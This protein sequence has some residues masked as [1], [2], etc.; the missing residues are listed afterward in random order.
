MGGSAKDF[1]G[2][3]RSQSMHC[4]TSEDCRGTV[5]GKD[6]HRRGQRLSP[7]GDGTV[8]SMYPNWHLVSG[9]TRCYALGFCLG[10]TI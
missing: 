8:E 4:L 9:S 10:F 5:G 3:N 1:M 6:C 7:F 2:H